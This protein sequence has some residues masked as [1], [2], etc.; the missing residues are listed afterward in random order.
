LTG[1]SAAPKNLDYIM[2][3]DGAK[4]GTV[5]VGPAGRGVRTAVVAAATS[6]LLPGR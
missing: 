4:I 1:Y 2:D 3:A 5:F 6:A